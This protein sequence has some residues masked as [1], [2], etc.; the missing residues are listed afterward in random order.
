MFY[1]YSVHLLFDFYVYAPKIGVVA[2]AWIRHC[3]ARYIGTYAHALWPLPGS[4]TVMLG[5][6]GAYVHALAL[7]TL[8]ITIY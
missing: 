4:A 2:P 7:Y 1:L 6:I 5:I 8:R 3:D